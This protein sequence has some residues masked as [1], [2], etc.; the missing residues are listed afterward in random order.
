MEEA[1]GIA[2]PCD[3]PFREYWVLESG[4]RH[5][6]IHRMSIISIVC[7][8]PSAFIIPSDAILR[9]REMSD[10]MFEQDYQQMQQKN[11][12]EVNYS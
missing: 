8:V 11:S 5:L 10:I 9:S 4:G 2:I 6:C 12:E 3:G 1:T 7:D